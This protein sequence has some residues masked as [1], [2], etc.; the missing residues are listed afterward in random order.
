VKTTEEQ[1]NQELISIATESESIG[2]L[3][4]T[5]GQSK[6]GNAIGEIDHFLANI[7]QF[8]FRL[9]WNIIVI[10]GTIWLEVI[11]IGF[12]F[13]SVVGIILLLIFMPEGFL[14]PLGLFSFVV[15]LW[16]EK[17]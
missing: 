12:I 7:I 16:P 15:K 17:E 11:W 14:L 4:Q 3:P 5:K 8:P 1:N 2:S 13:G 6:L 9:L 10:V